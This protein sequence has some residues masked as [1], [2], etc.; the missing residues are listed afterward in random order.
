MRNINFVLSIS[1][2]YPYG[3][4]SLVSDYVNRFNANYHALY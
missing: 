4:R 3:P 2:V 1:E